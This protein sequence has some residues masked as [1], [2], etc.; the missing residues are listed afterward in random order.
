MIDELVHTLLELKPPF[1]IYQLVFNCLL[2]VFLIKS[3]IFGI[4]HI[5][6]AF[7]IIVWWFESYKI[8]DTYLLLLFFCMSLGLLLVLHILMKD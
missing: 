7:M 1:C 5:L 3:L 8:M 4:M 6:N 2:L